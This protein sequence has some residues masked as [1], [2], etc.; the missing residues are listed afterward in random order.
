MEMRQD[1]GVGTHGLAVEKLLP[2]LLA[3]ADQAS[4]PATVSVYQDVQPRVSL[5]ASS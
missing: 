1:L 5:A 2:L 4:P 3:D